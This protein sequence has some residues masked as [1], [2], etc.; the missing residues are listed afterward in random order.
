MKQPKQWA[1]TAPPAAARDHIHAG[2]QDGNRHGGGSSNPQHGSAGMQ[3]QLSNSGS[4][5]STGG[6][7][8]NG[9]NM[10]GLLPAAGSFGGGS[11]GGGASH[12]PLPLPLRTHQPLPP[13]LIGG[14]AAATLS[15]GGA[16][17]PSSLPASGSRTDRGG[18]VA[19][20]SPPSFA[21]FGRL[22]I[23]DND[24]GLHELQP[25]GVSSSPR[26]N[27]N[28]GGVGGN[29]PVAGRRAGRAPPG[30][31]HGGGSNGGD[32]GI[33]SSAIL[34]RFRPPGMQNHDSGE[35]F[36]AGL[37]PPGVT[38]PSGDAGGALPPG[39]VRNPGGRPSHEALQ[40]IQPLSQMGGGQPAA[41]GGLGPI[42][43]PGQMGAVGG[44]NPR[45]RY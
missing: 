4:I 26:G 20:A 40:T 13:P 14:R 3:R 34:D 27:S 28:N 30:D 44:G 24:L 9:R 36:L 25:P 22:Q 41:G 29:V 32:A 17:Y 11:S 42:R 8:G 39:V 35:D 45:T 38:K 5:G 6:G 31:T 43:M 33:L 23:K 18:G 19:V 16:M 15:G 2:D 1:E 37:L 21:G 12:Q 10:M 7:S